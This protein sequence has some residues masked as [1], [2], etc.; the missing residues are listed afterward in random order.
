MHRRRQRKGG[1]LLVQLG[2]SKGGIVSY[3][4]NPL[5]ERKGGRHNP[6]DANPG[7]A[8][9]FGEGGGHGGLGMVECE[10]GGRRRSGRG[11]EK[12]AEDFVGEEGDVWV[13]GCEGDDGRECGGGEDGAGWVV[14]VA[15]QRLVSST[16]VRKRRE[17]YLM[18]MA[19]VLG[20]IIDFSSSRLASQLSDPRLSFHRLT[21]APWYCGTRKSCEYV[22]Y[23]QIT[24]SPGPA[25]IDRTR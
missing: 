13:V 24:W 18:M 21:S 19:F 8:V 16:E 25:K 3:T 17:A 4:H 2:Y 1:N 15:G 10:E 11:V 12:G 14:G 22:G 6:A 5:K 20:L 9:G 7:E 23:W